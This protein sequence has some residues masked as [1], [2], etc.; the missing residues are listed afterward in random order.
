[1]EVRAEW[2]LTPINSPTTETIEF[3]SI[4]FESPSLRSAKSQGFKQ[5]KACPQ[6][7]E[8]FSG[9]DQPWDASKSQWEDWQPEAPCPP[10]ADAEGE[11][12]MTTYRHSED[13]CVQRL[14]D[15]SSRVYIRLYWQAQAKEPGETETEDKETGE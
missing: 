5:V 15:A 7:I 2:G 10:P 14:G 9:P 11:N 8:V 6:V 1:M 13:V 3:E 4:A 12:W